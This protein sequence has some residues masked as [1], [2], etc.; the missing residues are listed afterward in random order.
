MLL[1][2][3]FSQILYS[4]CINEPCQVSITVAA[5]S[6]LNC[7]LGHLKVSHC[8]TTIKA[9]YCYRRFIMQAGSAEIKYFLF[10][11]E[12]YLYKSLSCGDFQW[13]SHVVH[14]NALL[15]LPEPLLTLLRL[16]FGVQKFLHVSFLKTEGS[17]KIQCTNSTD[18]N[19]TD[20]YGIAWQERH[21]AAQ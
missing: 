21:Q 14:E 8:T 6:I 15:C 13:S 10:P 2:H 17:S 1:F 11:Q 5:H 9:P 16:H 12:A 18:K 4:I 3:I 7:N 19:W 20:F